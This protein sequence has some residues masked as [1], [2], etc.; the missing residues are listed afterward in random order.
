MSLL[1]K[2]TSGRSYKDTLL[3]IP[4]GCAVA[5]VILSIW[6]M[7]R[8]PMPDACVIATATAD[9]PYGLCACD[10]F[11]SPT[12]RIVGLI[13]RLSIFFGMG[14][15]AARM[16]HQQRILAAASLATVVAALVVLADPG[17]GPC[18]GYWRSHVPGPLWIG[19]SAA[20]GA[21]GGWLMRRV[22]T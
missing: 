9:N 10:D 3:S 2:W 7:T 8:N 4:S 1:R 14:V 15:M 18:E 11:S 20:A 21:F 17:S 13:V 12:Q 16:T 19:A 5:A 22:L 6:A